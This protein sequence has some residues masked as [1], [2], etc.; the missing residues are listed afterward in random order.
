MAPP[1]R[2]WRISGVNRHGTAER[3]LQP[4]SQQLPDIYHSSDFNKR[5]VSTF[6]KMC[7]ERFE[8]FQL[9]EIRIYPLKY[10]GNLLNSSEESYK[11]DLKH[12][13]EE[14]TVMC[15]L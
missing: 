6:L 11:V 3:Y 12:T 4:C 14:V 8:L 10:E 2:L 15:D 9:H 13:L 1:W 7:S 5:L